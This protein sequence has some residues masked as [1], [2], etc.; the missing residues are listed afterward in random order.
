MNNTEDEIDYKIF[1]KI[2]IGLNKVSEGD[3]PMQLITNFQPPVNKRYFI[4]KVRHYYG[5]QNGYVTKA[6]WTQGR[7]RAWR[8]VTRDISGVLRQAQRVSREVK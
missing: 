8:L 1:D 3:T 4:W 2:G 5:P 6:Y 7:S